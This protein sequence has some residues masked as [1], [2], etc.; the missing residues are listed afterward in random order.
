[1]KFLAAIF[2]TLFLILPTSGMSQAAP[3]Y[4]PARGLPSFVASQTGAPP[5]SEVRTQEAQAK[6]L[7]LKLY[8]TSA[9]IHDLLGLAG[10]SNWTMTDAERSLLQQQVASVQGQLQTLEK[11]RYQFLYHPDDAAAGAKTL[12][13]LSSLIPQIA[14]IAKAA[15]S[16]GGAAAATQF[17]QPLDELSGLKDNLR[18]YLEARFP[19]QFPA[20]QPAAAAAPVAKKRPTAASSPSATAAPATQSVSSLPSSSTNAAP[21]SQTAPPASAAAGT[22]EIQPDQVKAVLRGVFLTDARVSD[23]LSLMQPEKWKMQDAERALFNERLET[24]AAQLKTVEKWRYQFLYNMGKT[25]LGDNV[26]SALGDLIPSIR[27]IASGVAQYQ[28]PAAGAGF[29]QAAGQLAGFKDSIASYVALLQAQYQKALTAHPAGGPGGKG[30]ETERINAPPPPAPPVRTLVVAPPPLTVAE[31]KAIL[32]NVYVSEFRVRDLLGQE[33][34]ERWKAPP[35]ERELAAQA[36][37]GLL[38]QLN[39]LEKW[40]EQF[41]RDP[42]NMYNAFQTY[43]AVDSVFHPLRVFS[44]ETAKYE[45]ANMASDYQ[46]RADDME[47]QMNGL[48][49]YIGFILQ[50]ADQGLETFQSDLASCQNELS[51]AMHGT[52]HT[53]ASMKNIVPVF[54]GRR[55]GRK[56]SK[57]KESMRK[58]SRRA[59]HK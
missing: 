4:A 40:R 5:E 18:S 50:H 23:L 14:P 34:P 36:R 15:D 55:T 57:E 41:N 7:L 21:T 25:D 19:S 49:P 56:A 44:R 43:R 17:K 30:L 11:W 47:A 16:Y 28:T 51:Y 13:T 29:N 45:S 46:R 52:V 3:A 48:I 54:R 6:T 2:A 20:P 22:V 39:E 8:M 53:P 27:D 24:V 42:A 12:D 37:T 33:H 1:M 9:R 10:A 26:V 35:A 32:H 38:A 58:N 59:A 31:V